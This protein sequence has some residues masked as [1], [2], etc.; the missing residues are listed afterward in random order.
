MQPNPMAQPDP[1]AEMEN[2]LCDLLAG[3]SDDEIKEVSALVEAMH[4]DGGQ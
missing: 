3:L 2:H 1:D 4:A